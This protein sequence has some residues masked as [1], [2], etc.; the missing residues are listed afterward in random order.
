MLL[1]LGL[2]LKL[3]GKLEEALE[4]FKRSLKI[5]DQIFGENHPES[6]INYR[7][8]GLHFE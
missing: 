6:A 4:F 8:I 7:F 1:I 5:K 2:A 3:K